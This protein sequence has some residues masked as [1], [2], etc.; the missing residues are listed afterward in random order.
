[1]LLY[2]IYFLFES[3]A[4][5]IICIWKLLFWHLLID[6]LTEFLKIFTVIK[7]WVI[8]LVWLYFIELYVELN[9]EAYAYQF[10]SPILTW[11]SNAVIYAAIW[12]NVLT[13]RNKLESIR[14]ITLKLLSYLIHFDVNNLLRNSLIVDQRWLESVE[15]IRTYTYMI[16]C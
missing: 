16:R 6:L 10:Y 3:S 9:V 15:L 7:M 8:E 1:M 14:N 5:T 13:V 2:S 12:F 11:S 4:I